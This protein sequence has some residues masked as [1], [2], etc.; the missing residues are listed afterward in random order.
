[1]GRR[2]CTSRAA[3]LPHESGNGV[4]GLL[5]NPTG[6]RDRSVSQSVKGPA[7]STRPTATDM[8]GRC[9][10]FV[11]TR[12]LLA[13]APFFLL[14]TRGE[15]LAGVDSVLSSDGCTWAAGGLLHDICSMY[16]EEYLSAPYDGCRQEDRLMAPQVPYLLSNIQSSQSRQSTYGLLHR[17]R[18]AA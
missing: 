4:T 17:G 5:G 7:L 2:A 12:G 16:V 15:L 1:M 3:A 11:C 8:G 14:G 13:P 18:Q 9:Q 6:G 10:C